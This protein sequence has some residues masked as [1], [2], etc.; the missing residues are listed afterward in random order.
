[1]NRFYW[2]TTTHT[3]VIKMK[4]KQKKLKISQYIKPLVQKRKINIQVW[5][6]GC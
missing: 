3:R 6:V 5:A 1:M 4:I 2:P